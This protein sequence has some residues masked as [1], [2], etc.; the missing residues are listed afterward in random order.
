MTNLINNYISNEKKR[1]EVNSNMKDLGRVML[2]VSLPVLA[3]QKAYN[4]RQEDFKSLFNFNP[5]GTRRPLKDIGRSISQNVVSSFQTN[6]EIKLQE[7][8]MYG[9][10][11]LDLIQGNDALSS[12]MNLEGKAG[13]R[14]YIEN[15]RKET[16]ALLQSIRSRAED[17][18]GSGFH[19]DNVGAL[20]NQL[21]NA[22]VNIDS[23]INVASNKVSAP[24]S[25]AKQTLEQTNKQIAYFVTNY[26]T[27]ERQSIVNFGKTYKNY[28][29]LSDNIWTLDKRN[30][31][32]ARQRMPLGNTSTTAHI[33]YN[34]KSGTGRNILNDSTFSTANNIDDVFLHLQNN[35]NSKYAR[36][37]TEQKTA[38]SSQVTSLYNDYMNILKSGGSSFGG[39]VNFNIVEEFRH[40]LPSIYM[41]TR[42]GGKEIAFALNLA[43]DPTTG[44][45][46]QRTTSYMGAREA[47]A[48]SYIDATELNKVISSPGSRAE[49]IRR[50]EILRKDATPE[51]FQYS[52]FKSITDAK[53]LSN[54]TNRDM[55]QFLETIRATGVVSERMTMDSIIKNTD[56]DKNLSRNLKNAEAIQAN[57]AILTNMHRLQKNDADAFLGRLISQNLGFE[58]VIGASTTISKMPIDA[59][60]GRDFSFGA[61]GINYTHA[62]DDSGNPIVKNGEFAIEKKFNPMNALQKFGMLNRAVQPIVA[63]EHQIFGKKEMIVGMVPSKSSDKKIINA[64]DDYQSKTIGRFGGLKAFGQGDELV[65]ISGNE[66]GKNIRGINLLG[67]LVVD[68]DQ[69]RAIAGLGEG[70]AYYGGNVLL[71]QARDKTIVVTDSTATTK[72]HEEILAAQAN[73]DGPGYLHIKGK[74]E[75]SNFFQKYGGVLGEGDAGSIIKLGDLSTLEEIKIK[76]AELTPDNQRFK[77]S[78]VAELTSLEPDLKIFSQMIKTTGQSNGILNETMMT[79]LMHRTFFQSSDAERITKLAG[80]SD[81][82]DLDKLARESFNKPFSSLTAEEQSSVRSMHAA[83]KAKNQI[84]EALGMSRGEKDLS[85]FVF[86]DIGQ[87]KK[88]AKYMTDVFSG[89]LR[90]IGYNLAD[91]EKGGLFKEIV[92]TEMGT[93]VS[94]DDLNENLTFTKDQM[95]KASQKRFGLSYDKINQEQMDELATQLNKLKEAGYQQRKYVE[96]FTKR[97]FDVI[98]N[99][100]TDKVFKYEYDVISKGK[101]TRV[102]KEIRSDENFKTIKDVQNYIS[103]KN[104]A[105]SKSSSG[106]ISNIK[107]EESKF[108]PTGEILGLLFAGFRTLADKK[109]NF[110]FKKGGTEFESLLEKEA[111]RVGYSKEERSTMMAFSKSGLMLGAAYANA[112]PMTSIMGT[113]LAALEP[114]SANQYLTKLM[115]DF[116]LSPEESMEHFGTML[117]RQKDFGKKLSLMQQMRMTNL[118]L[119]KLTDTDLYAPEVQRL[120]ESGALY[121]LSKEETEEFKRIASNQ[122]GSGDTVNSQI[123]DF[124]GSRKTSAGIAINIEDISPNKAVQD[125]IRNIIGKNKNEIILPGG[126]TIEALETATIKKAGASGGSMAIENETLRSIGDIFFHISNASTQTEPSKYLQSS[127]TGIQKYIGI[128]GQEYGHMLRNLNTVEMQG[129]VTLVGGGFSLGKTAIDTKED[130]L[131]LLNRGRST[132]TLGISD[133]KENE[134]RL[135]NMRA[136][137]EE[138]HGYAGFLDTRGF[139]D[140]LDQFMGG[141]RNDFD[142]R[143]SNMEN[144]LDPSEKAYFDEHMNRRRQNLE[145]KGLEFTPIE[146]QKARIDARN[147]MS[148]KFYNETVS[149]FLLGMEKGATYNP[150]TKTFDTE[151]FKPMGIGGDTVRHPDMQTGNIN[152][153]KSFYKYVDEKVISGSDS[154]QNVLY[155]QEAHERYVYNK[156]TK[157]NELVR[158]SSNQAHLANELSGIVKSKEFS[159]ILDTAQAGEK[160]KIFKQLGYD[161]SKSDNFKIT[162]FNQLRILH[163]LSES[164]LFKDQKVFNVTSVDKESGKILLDRETGEAIVKQKTLK[165][166]VNRVL[167][168]YVKALQET[169]GGGR[170]FF[171]NNETEVTYDVMK[172]GSYSGTTKEMKAKRLDFSRY[173]IG[174][175]DG[176]TYMFSLNTNNRM[177]NKMVKQEY[178]QQVVE[179]MHRYGTE[180]LMYFDLLAQGVDKMG[181]RLGKASQLSVKEYAK[182]DQLKEQAIKANVGEVDVAVKKIIIGNLNE[183]RKHSN[184]NTPEAIEKVKANMSSMAVLASSVEALTIKSKKLPLASNIAKSMSQ[185]LNVATESGDMEPIQKFLR[186]FLQGTDIE[187]GVRI[188]SI[189]STTIPEGSATDLMFKRMGE[190][191]ADQMHLSLDSVFEGIRQGANAVRNNELKY[192]STNKES[193]KLFSSTNVIEDATSYNRAMFGVNSQ[194]LE[195]HFVKDAAQGDFSLV[196][197]IMED[198]RIH[199]EEQMQSVDNIVKRTS[200]SSVYALGASALGAGYL[201]GPS[202]DTTPLEGPGQ[203][204]D[205]K[206]NQAISNK[207]MYDKIKQNPQTD[208]PAENVSHATYRDMVVNR[209]INMGETMV[210]KNENYLMYGELPNIQS[211]NTTASIISRHGG[212]ASIRI[213]DN[214]MPIT[215]NYIDRILG[216]R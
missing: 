36:F 150:T 129:A 35:T 96:N 188:K 160:E 119:S 171:V 112:G 194:A 20:L 204:S 179:R 170:V 67:L 205:Y 13:N 89:G 69:A 65:G 38:F 151:T 29:N 19:D 25:M 126:E 37:S 143:F 199:M 43:A 115:S 209:P 184:I 162:G 87:A 31:A 41:N 79:E 66:I 168:G 196:N 153:F 97:V 50:L 130:R 107:I 158:T 55:N 42:V 144:Y 40:E 180:F 167:T 94:F 5:G 177:R 145:A 201:L 73:P 149:S 85:H 3:M 110:N 92:D 51:R 68:D 103:K 28:L 21:D 15:V 4:V 212:T 81:P 53:N 117:S 105:L 206:V 172:N 155:R 146:Q 165:S 216:E 187:E 195:S 208:V 178:G 127:E 174:D 59:F 181:E 189:K 123:K 95:D 58:G 61:V 132:H 122:S 198:M 76:G 45:K 200:K 104:T 52:L 140:A 14:V 136:A 161:P 62:L 48:N 71:K 56:F 169:K 44:T 80:A 30:P 74:Q 32:A 106:K 10:K 125:S 88:S 49:R 120:K 47:M 175:Y 99:T 9:R 54:L 91:F 101:T 33:L 27:S 214:R 11:I 64:L 113:N 156:A 166:S 134:I 34:S 137:F 147:K 164:E 141:V 70:S 1:E 46:Y 213:A 124:L 60:G 128:L 7:D 193:E 75:I 182:Q 142:W 139:T 148:S 24:D 18:H 118:S 152:M 102:Q 108:K 157:T 83:K 82:K 86:A 211:M 63:R 23:M 114:R 197:N 116:R 93:G 98:K 191:S 78:F 39:N 90:A 17:L 176:D 22:M 84:F 121:T 185:A 190:G 159:N 77:M 72:L 183:I 26:N 133:L 135:N 138:S 192:I 2:G 57:R 207:T 173:G 163:D 131:S 210:N 202:I 8:E 203:F 100:S 109:G 215:G 154:L 186:S 6:R 111:E 12:F 16:I